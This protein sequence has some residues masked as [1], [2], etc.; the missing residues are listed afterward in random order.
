MTTKLTPVQREELRQ[1]GNQPVPVVEPA[2]NAV[3]FL[4]AG[5]VYERLRRVL[6]ADAMDVRETYAAQSDAA[7]QSGWDDP[8]MDVYDSYD[9][10]RPQ[11]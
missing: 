3:Y 4:V 10:H 11:P 2:T 1:H 6:D 8:E 5:E 9:S 7:G